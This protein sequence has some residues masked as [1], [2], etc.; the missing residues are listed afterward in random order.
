MGYD[1]SRAAARRIQ[2]D[3]DEAESDGEAVVDLQVGDD[4]LRRTFDGSI[5]A[6]D[7]LGYAVEVR[8]DNVLLEAEF[9]Q[10]A[11]LGRPDSDAL[12]ALAADLVREIGS[13]Q[14]HR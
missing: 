6:D 4:A 2:R 14:P 11:T 5:G 1:D 10:S 8:I 3:R 13:R 12:E 7:S 9:D